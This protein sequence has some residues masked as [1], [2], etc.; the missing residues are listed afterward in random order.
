MSALIHVKIV[1]YARKCLI[2]ES[3]SQIIGKGN[4]MF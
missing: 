1:L 2:Y 3:Y 4:S